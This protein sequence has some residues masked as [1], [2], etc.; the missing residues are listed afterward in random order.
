MKSLLEAGTFL[1][2]L[3]SPTL[4]MLEHN[5]LHTKTISYS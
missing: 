1:S 4:K 5:G 2:S 3:G